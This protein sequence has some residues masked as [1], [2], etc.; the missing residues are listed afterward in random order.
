[1]RRLL[2]AELSYYYPG[3]FGLL[4]CSSAVFITIWLGIKWE[5]NRIPMTMLMVLVLSIS[6]LQGAEMNRNLQKRDRLHVLLPVALWRIGISHLLYPMGILSGIFCIYYFTAGILA[7]F[8]NQSLTMLSIFH[9]GTLI[10]LVLIFNALILLFRDLN[11]SFNRKFPLVIIILF[12]LL[13]Y[14][15]A[16]LPFYVV[17]NFLELFGEN[18]R[19]Q[20]FL[21]GIL[22]SPL[23]FVILG[24]LLSGFSL[25]VF[26]KRETYVAS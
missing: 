18:T 17:T 15:A 2:K 24:L 26:I 23:V 19:L 6:A 14:L 20:N 21:S 3:I 8:F 22:A 10:G 16:L 9:V 1:V 4:L 11:R 25:A 12:W 5:R 7:F 13:F